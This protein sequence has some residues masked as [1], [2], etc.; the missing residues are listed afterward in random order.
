MLIQRKL[1]GGG[2]LHSLAVLELAPAADEL[3]VLEADSGRGYLWHARGVVAL[4]DVAR[5][6]KLRPRVTAAYASGKATNVARVFDAF[7]RQDADTPLACRARDSL[8]ASLVTFLPGQPDGYCHP[9]VPGA[10]LSQFTPGG[11]YLACLQARDFR[12]VELDL[13]VLPA[14]AETQVDRRC[15]NIVAEDGRELVNFSPPL[16][17]ERAAA[18]SVLEY[19]RA[20]PVADVVALAG[21]LPVVAG[22][23]G[24]GLYAD[25]ITLLRSRRPDSVISLDVGGAPLQ[26]CLQRGPQA[27]PT[28]ACINL[29]EYSGIPRGLWEQYRGIAVVHDK[30]G[31]WVLQ[32]EA[33]SPAELVRRRRDVEV[34]PDVQVR[35]TICAGDA[36]HGGLLLG[37][38][39]FGLTG[40]GLWR[41]AVLS[42]A[43]ALTVV[44]GHDSIRGLTAAKVEANV[45]RFV[46]AWHEYA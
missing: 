34:P 20:A 17:W 4:P 33:V 41:A 16:Y 8:K 25:I 27:S 15:A 37:L 6:A 14:A 7:L 2:Q 42:Q 43:C 40:E 13:Q 36:A 11:A 19:A 30:G 3:W 35:H 26:A 24:V 39:L 29:A 12:A 45:Q 32:A 38:M 28:V 21:S 10:L 18:D 44:E 1:T 5:G 23:A 31:C 46:G 22:E 9:H